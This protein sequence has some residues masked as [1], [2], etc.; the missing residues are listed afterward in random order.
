MP[1]G[2]ECAVAFPLRFMVDLDWQVVEA[3]TL[4]V[5]MIEIIVVNAWQDDLRPNAG[6][7][8]DCTCALLT[9]FSPQVKLVAPNVL[10]LLK[11]LTRSLLPRGS[12]FVSAG[13]N[14]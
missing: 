10:F 2:D 5:A 3:P 6:W 12:R 9:I 13:M 4:I 14:K 1:L 7:L 8:L 11:L